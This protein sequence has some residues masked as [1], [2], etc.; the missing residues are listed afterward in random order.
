MLLPLMLVVMVSKAVADWYVPS[1]YHIVLE[2]NPDVHLL[3]DNL[4]EDHWVVLGNL[5][6]HDVCTAEVVVLQ[7]FETIKSIAN[8]LLTTSFAAYP[9]I[10]RNQRLLGLVGRAQLT[11]ILET[12]RF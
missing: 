7:E 2:A 1:V 3:E 5:T 9:I 4:S 6:I 12:K 10:D 8:V 11:T